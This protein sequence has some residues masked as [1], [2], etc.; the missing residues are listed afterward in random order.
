MGVGAG[1]LEALAGNAGPGFDLFG[2]EPLEPRIDLDQVRDAERDGGPVRAFRAARAGVE[3][4]VDAG[5]ACHPDLE[6]L[7]L[8]PQRRRDVNARGPDLHRSPLSSSTAWPVR[9]A[10]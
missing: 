9:S 3:G 2:D 1:E 5:R 8:H 4:I 10:S 6:A 7:E